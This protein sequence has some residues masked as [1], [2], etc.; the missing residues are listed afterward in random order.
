[1]PH[2][3]KGAEFTAPLKQV[4]GHGSAKSGTH[5]WI[6]QRLTSVA[7]LILMPWALWAVNAHI[8]GASYAEVVA[9]IAQPLNAILAILLVITIHYHAVLGLQT[10]I[11]DYIH[12]EGLKIFKLVGQRLLYTA[13]AI[14]CIYALTSISL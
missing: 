2:Y 4:K 9:W 6:M 3:K 8:V 13:S 1:M 10:V 14:A 5:H 11:E 7:L 12:H